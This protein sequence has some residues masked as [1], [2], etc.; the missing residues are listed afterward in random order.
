M[1]TNNGNQKINCAVT[2]CKYNDTK[3]Q[4]CELQAIVVK[5]CEQCNT[6]NAEDESM[7]GNYQYKHE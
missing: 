4:T 3:E 1:D 7:C 5:P 2:S 6:G